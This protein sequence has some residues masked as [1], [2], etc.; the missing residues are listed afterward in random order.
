MFN[1]RNSFCTVIICIR[2]PIN[3]KSFSFS[4]PKCLGKPC[5]IVGSDVTHPSPQMQS[6]T[7]PI[8]AVMKFPYFPWNMKRLTESPCMISWLTIWLPQ[9]TASHDP[10]AQFQY[11]VEIRLQ[12]PKV[13]IIKDLAEIMKNQ[14]RFF[15]RKTGQKPQR[16][17]FYRSR[18]KFL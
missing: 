8:A 5:I 18:N 13:E 12:S 10:N 7:P 11:N 17:I 9:V 16:I 14:L 4:R 3:T 6:V 15:Y 2:P 1:S